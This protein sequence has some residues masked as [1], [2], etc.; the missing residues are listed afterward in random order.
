LQ[1]GSKS[2][3]QSLLSVCNTCHEIGHRTKYCLTTSESER[4]IQNDAK[5]NDLFLTLD[6]KFMGEKIEMENNNCKLTNCSNVYKDAVIQSNCE[7]KT[8]IDKE[9]KSCGNEKKSIEVVEILDD[10]DTESSVRKEFLNFF[11]SK[12]LSSPL[13]NTFSWQSHLKVD[14]GDKYQTLS[15]NFKTP[16]NLKQS[17][18]SLALPDLELQE[19]WGTFSPNM[20]S[21]NE[22]RSTS[23]LLIN[24]DLQGFNAA[25][26][27]YVTHPDACFGLLSSKRGLKPLTIGILTSR[28]NKFVRKI[29]RVIP[30]K[31][32]SK[33][34]KKKIV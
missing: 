4:L 6:S 8:C 16:D 14:E 32:M 17:F 12:S 22:S 25:P 10:S 11:K 7:V 3:A 28:L 15:N 18:G 34:R 9:T 30:N 5:E 13:S 19:S 33:K 27:F 1:C 2:I 26:K 23:N 20:S 29:S 31:D 21:N 24:Q